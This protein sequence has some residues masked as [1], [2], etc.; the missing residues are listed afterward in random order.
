MKRFTDLS[1]TVKFLSIG[2]VLILFLCSGIV[3][4]YVHEYQNN[5]IAAYV[6]KSRA[7]ALAAESTRMEMD[8]KWQRGI[9][10]SEEV[11]AYAEQGEIDRVLDTIPVVT[12]W[13][14]AMKKSHQGEYEFRVPKF[15]PRNMSNTPDHGLD[16]EIEGP[17]LKKIKKENLKEY[18]VID[19]E[20][21]AVRYFLPVRLT[22]TCMM[23][24]GDPSTSEKLWGLPDGQD[25]TGGTM[26]NWKVG[27]V[28]GAFEIIQSLDSADA[29]LRKELSRILAITVVG[30]FAVSAGYFLLV[31]WGVVG[32]VDTVAHRLKQIAQG[33]ADLTQR[34]IAA[35][36]DEM[37]E[38]VN[39]F[40]RFI[41]NLQK[42]VKQV[43]ENTSVI[44]KISS[45]LLGISN[46]MA[47]D[48]KATFT[49]SDSVA[50]ASNL[51]SEN[52]TSVDHA[53]KEATANLSIVASSAEEMSATIN[54][55]S[56]NSSNARHIS[57]QGVQQAKVAST[58]VNE[59][60]E[61]AQGIGKVTETIA[62]ISDQTNL[63]ALNATIEAARAG[64]AGKG[65]N[66][67]A[68]EIKELS[69]QTTL[70][71]NEIRKQ[72]EQ[73]QTT[74]ASTLQEINNVMKV[75]EQIDSLI[76][77]VATAVEEQS[78]ATSEIAGNISQASQSIENISEK[79][80]ES[81]NISSKINMDI[82]ELNEAALSISK[83][84]EQINTSVKMLENM[85]SSL[86]T[87]VE[88]FT[89]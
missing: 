33:D 62:D 51:M 63:L 85:A 67:V 41:E 70:A 38:L 89:V 45:Q 77:T 76:Y 75:I 82:N 11:R 47:N 52:M 23:C 28:H 57:N 13:R 43:A 54:E 71:T 79:V 65:F 53:M 84:G 40:N 24:H 18:Y 69:Q 12:A 30:L 87:L 58:K 1:L 46:N 36:K 86:R 39:W 29:L 34:L 44:N 37:G 49:K 72:I 21:N 15:S 81:S 27:E 2:I 9:F 60:N 48:S 31:R 19:K 14:A 8:E 3:G 56:S 5:T 61:A 25:P 6:E 55:I 16:Y 26:E 59:L 64:E 80:A 74:T 17:A 88:K 73:V 7:I 35:S 10:T 4:Y 83:G 50:K 22:D 78:I 68:N 66:V 32:P 20:R 42:M